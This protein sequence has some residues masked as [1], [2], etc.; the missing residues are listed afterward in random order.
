MSADRLH[1]QPHGSPDRPP[2]ILL[3]G[4]LGDCHDFDE[5]VAQLDSFYCLSL[6]LP[7]H[8]QTLP[9]PDC[10]MENTALAI[11]EWLHDRQIPQTHLVGYSMGGRLALYLAI[12]FPQHFPKVLL[13]SASPGLATEAERQARTQADY[14]WA[15]RLEANFPQFLTDWYDQ[16]LFHSLKAHPNFAQM[17]KRRHHNN[18]AGLAQSLRQMGTGQQPSLWHRLA[19]HRHPLLWVV[20][21]RDRKFVT[22]NQSLQQVC[23]TA[24]LVIIPEAGHNVH[25]EQPQRFADCVRQFFA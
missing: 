1:Y 16:P 18:P 20:G 23:P 7:G 15:D 8:G 24:Q 14:G 21:E 25:L 6:D 12:H 19:T 2:L 10:G 22:L 11:V 3:H 5:V 17:Q 4:F 9:L 13:E